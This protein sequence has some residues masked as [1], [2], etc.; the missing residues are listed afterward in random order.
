MTGVQLPHTGAN[1]TG[2]P[3]NTRQILLQNVVFA[4]SRRVLAQYAASNPCVIHVPSAPEQSLEAEV[5]NAGEV[6]EGEV[7]EL[8]AECHA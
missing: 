7:W 3:E 4:P 6:E 5:L 8:Y 2:P 1:W